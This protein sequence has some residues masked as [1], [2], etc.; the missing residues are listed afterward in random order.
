VPLDKLPIYPALFL[1]PTFPL[2]HL[3]EKPRPLLHSHENLWL[4]NRH[5]ELSSYSTRIIS[6]AVF[7]LS[8]FTVIIIP[9]KRL[10]C[11]Q[12]YQGSPVNSTNPTKRLPIPHLFSSTSDASTFQRCPCFM[13]QVCCFTRL[14][15]SRFREPP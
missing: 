7:S 15:R 9:G 6:I 12:I 1:Q 14:Y 4:P 13:L 10:G 8:P 11:P 5:I 2:L 3:T